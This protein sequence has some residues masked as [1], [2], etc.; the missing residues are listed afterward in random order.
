MSKDKNQKTFQRIEKKYL[1]SQ[2]QYN[3]LMARLQDHIQP[4]EFCKSTI[5]NIYFDTPDYRLIRAS[6]EKPVYKEKLRLRSYGIPSPESKVFVE[7]K[8]KYCGVVYKR[9][10]P[11]SLSE[12]ERYLSHSIHPARESQ[13]LHE[14]DWFKQFYEGL[15]PAVYLSYDRE[16]YV[17]RENPNLRFTFDSNIRWRQEHLRLEDGVGGAELLE[18][19]RHLMELKIPGALPIWLVRLLEE[20][21]ISQSSYSKYGTV[22]QNYLVG[23]VAAKGGLISA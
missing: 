5:C 21:K 15:R 17:D 6:L 23:E 19:D 2:E 13:I 16:A 18:K 20:L 7:I 10:V 4:D 11:M 1:L 22:Y 14:I 9:R 3:A 12:A 8:K